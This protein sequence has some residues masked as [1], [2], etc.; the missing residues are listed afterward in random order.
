MQMLTTLHYINSVEDNYILE[1]LLHY[2]IIC[3]WL[4]KPFDPSLDPPLFKSTA[5]NNY[6]TH[7]WMIS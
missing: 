2:R 6:H 1:V 4:V 3:H 5:K 7:I